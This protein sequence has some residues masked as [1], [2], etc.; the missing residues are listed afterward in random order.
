MQTIP[1]PT[2]SKALVG[3]PGGQQLCA[4]LHR[5][6]Q[7]AQVIV[8]PHPF[9]TA[10]HSAPG[11]PHASGTQASTAAPPACPPVAPVGPPPLDEP[12]LE[13]PPLEVPP[14]FGAFVD[15]ELQPNATASA[16]AAAPRIATDPSIRFDDISH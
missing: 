10:P 8:A 6:T 3:F 11:D 15:S 9:G 4:E 14:V 12:P 13:V 5:P 7:P 16:K 1:L 2:G